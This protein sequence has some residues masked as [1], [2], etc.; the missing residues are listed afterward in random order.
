MLGKKSFNF[1]NLSVEDRLWGSKS[2]DFCMYNPNSSF[3]TASQTWNTSYNINI[4]LCRGIR[5][6]ISTKSSACWI[7]THFRD[8]KKEKRKKKRKKTS[9]SLLCLSL[10]Q[11]A[12]DKELTLPILKN[13]SIRTW[14]ANPSESYETCHDT[15]IS[16][17][18]MKIVSCFLFC[19]RRRPQIF[20][21]NPDCHSADIRSLNHLGKLQK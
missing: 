21:S 15:W 1:R 3:S 16:F 10:D 17:Q 12:K 9:N 2:T 20:S 19:W 18:H 4:W 7:V 14:Q 11:S 13:H 6:T 5:Y 8:S